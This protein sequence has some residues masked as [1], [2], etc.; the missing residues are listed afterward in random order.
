MIANG[1]S[2]LDEQIREQGL[3][4]K[5]LESVLND[6][7]FLN[8][9]GV[10]K[11][12][13]LYFSISTRSV[14]VNN[15]CDKIKS[16]KFGEVKPTFEFKK[17]TLKKTSNCG[18]IVNGIDNIKV[19]LSQCCRPIPGDEIVGYITRGKGVK[20]HCKNCPT[21]ATLDNR[22]I[23]VEWDSSVTDNILHQANLI[24]RASDRSNLLIEIMNLL[25]TLKITVLELNAIT[26]K[27]N[28]NASVQLS[29]MVKDGEHLR[30]IMNSIKNVK[31]V[32]EV[33]RVEH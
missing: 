4:D 3:N 7:N 17:R 1:K 23:N 5:N 33:L 10:A 22:L 6:V 15:V 26:H 14:N 29:V 13:D 8:L 9:F 24:I 28:L 11:L 16:R 32:F 25:S 31:G 18:V 2:L 12:E 20:V 27:D 30:T 19:E 21:L